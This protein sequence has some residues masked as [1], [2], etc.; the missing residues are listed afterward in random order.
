MP[1]LNSQI[2]ELIRDFS[3]SLLMVGIYTI[4]HPR[5]KSALDNL[6]GQ[7]L[8]IFKDTDELHLGVVGD[9]IFSGSNIFFDLTSQ[10][11]DFINVLKEKNLEF[12]RFKK[13]LSIEELCNFLEE[14][15]KRKKED[16][17]D[18]SETITKDA[19]FVHIRTG[20]F[21]Q[22]AE[23]V[24]PIKDENLKNKILQIHSLYQKQLDEVSSIMT[25]DILSQEADYSSLLTV[26]T[27][28]FNLSVHHQNSLFILSGLKKHDDYTFVHCVN[29]AILTMFQARIL[30]LADAD[31]VKL[32]IAAFLHD[33]G[34]IA[35]RRVLL[36]K[37]DTLTDAEFR[38]IKNHIILGSKL[39]LKSPRTEKLFLIVNFQH[40]IGF[41]LKGYPKTKFL[42][43]QNLASR[44]VSISD[45][46]DAL[47]SRRSYR[48]GLSLEGL[49]DIMKKE[50]GRL[51]DPYLLELFFK[52]LGVWPVGTL[53]MLDTKEVG[54][55]VKNNPED[56]FRPEVEIFFNEQGNKLKESFK[57]DLTQKNGKEE[58]TRRIRRHLNPS[59]EGQKYV[60]ELFGEI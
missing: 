59:G 10:V 35:I 32:G 44:L 31:I 43:R 54:L 1:D 26:A 3:S 30:G 27:Q 6:Y 50:K 7:F 51:F 55:V 45:V 49:Y 28:L 56:I 42:R 14:L 18:F 52:N 29:T 24:L 58:F 15:S 23:D 57:V 16:C 48:E 53:V 22:K 12:I 21:G 11:K 39:L 17:Q 46:Y 47:R 34:K 13:G 5:A 19:R 36:D 20:R 41:N 37:K 38:E 25:K 2:K 9:E 60:T 4:Q 33:I 40:H 8:N